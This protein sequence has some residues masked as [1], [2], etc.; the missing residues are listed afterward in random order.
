MTTSMKFLDTRG[1]EA[2]HGRK[3]KAASVGAWAFRVSDT[4]GRAEE[5][6]VFRPMCLRDAMLVAQIEALD[7]RGLEP[8]TVAVL[9]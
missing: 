8:A 5:V 9:P 3:P 1:Y 2:T 6:I 4:S 7:Q